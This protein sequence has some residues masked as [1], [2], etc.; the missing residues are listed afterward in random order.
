MKVIKF[1]QGD[2]KTIKSYMDS[3][4][5][6]ELLVET[7]HEV[8][9]HLET[10][11][12]CA[13]ELESRMRVKQVLQRAVKK[14]VASAG[15]QYRIQ[16]E[17]RKQQQPTPG[18]QWKTWVLAAAAM[19]IV[20]IG[21][22][23]V[24]QAIKS[25]NAKTLAQAQQQ[26]VEVLTVG[27][28]NHLHCA[29]DRQFAN[30]HFTDEEMNMKLGADFIGLVSLV[31][32]K[33]PGGFEVVVGHRCSFKKREY[34]HLILKNQEKVMSL[35]LTRKNG[36]AFAKAALGNVIQA[37]GIPL[38]SDRLDDYEVTGFETHDYFAFVVSNMT[39]QESELVASNLAPAVRDY[40]A[41]M[42]S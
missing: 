10:C 2:C 1:A 21:S 35:V 29:I 26:D 16:R 24:F 15:L 25:N 5:N 23:G 30:K 13:M 42:E 18:Y 27:L 17:I 4:M 37:A 6:D 9:K 8:L 22:W 28:N 41:K 11:K 19:L 14:D 40:L 34:I 33:V 32:D 31:K 3:Y 38:H 39:K 36:E 7:N 20:A 12:D